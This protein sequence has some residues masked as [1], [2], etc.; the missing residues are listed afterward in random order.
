MVTSHRV[1]W[2]QLHPLLEQRSHSLQCLASEHVLALPVGASWRGEG[3]G[4]EEGGGEEGGGG[5]GRVLT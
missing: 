4:G 1:L 3:G 2:K 5:E